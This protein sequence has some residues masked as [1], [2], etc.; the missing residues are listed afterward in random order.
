MG[1]ICCGQFKAAGPARAEYIQAQTKYGSQ[2]SQMIVATDDRIQFVGRSVVNGTD[3]EYSYASGVIRFLVKG[4]ASSISI[5][6]GTP[7][8]GTRGKKMRGLGGKN[9]GGVPLKPG[10][11][12]NVYHNGVHVDKIGVDIGEARH[13]IIAQNLSAQTETLIEVSR[14]SEGFSGLLIFKGIFLPETC[15]LLQPPP[16]RKL[17]EFVGDSDTTAQVGLGPFTLNFSAIFANYVTWGDAD[18]GWAH[19]VARAFGCDYINSSTGGI[20]ICYQ[21]DKFGKRNK[22]GPAHEHYDDKINFNWGV[23]EKDEKFS[24]GEMGPVDLVVVWLGQNDVVAGH[25]PGKVAEGIVGYEKLLSAI[26]KHRV[27]TP[28]LCLY[29]TGIIHTNHPKNPLF[30]GNKKKCLAVNSDIKAYI[31][32]AIEKWGGDEKELNIFARGFEMSPAFDPATDYGAFGE[33]GVG[34]ARKLARGTLPLVKEITGW[35]I[36]SE[37]SEKGRHGAL[38]ETTTAQ[39][40][41]ETK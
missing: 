19:Y 16:K 5:L 28:I 23:E 25:G 15:E 11:M 13:C 30:G 36:V 22:A 1:A 27:E 26:R 37:V 34:G 41:T 4:P 31:N 2:T 20:G 10:S 35:E 12:M 40:V 33:L 24:V 17:I 29:P 39:Y 21:G 3:R 9:K 38:P 14:C 8:N 7:K 6:C 18:Y 32:G